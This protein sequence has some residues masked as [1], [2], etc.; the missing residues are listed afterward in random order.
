M[1]GDGG[2]RLGLGAQQLRGHHL[3]GAV[4]GAGGRGDAPPE[5]EGRHRSGSASAGPR[6]DR[7]G[8]HEAAAAAQAGPRQPTHGHAA[9]ARL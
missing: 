7:S 2:R 6:G 9:A 8:V 5:S 4:R 1:D 3:A